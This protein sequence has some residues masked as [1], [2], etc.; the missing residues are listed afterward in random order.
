ME[1][2][3][4]FRK[5][6]VLFTLVQLGIPDLLSCRERATLQEIAGQLASG[7][8]QPSHD[9][10]ERLLGAGAALGLLE[11]QAGS[12][13]LSPVAREYLP[14]TA[15]LSLAG[16]VVHSDKVPRP[17]AAPAAAAAM[18]AAPRSDALPHGMWRAGGIPALRAAGALGAGRRQCLAARVRRRRQRH[19]RGHLPHDGG[20]AAVHGRHAQ[21]QPPQRAG[22]GVCL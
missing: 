21:L 7:Q 3:N 13:S 6:K 4:G 14:S 11:L 5:S 12:Y 16:Y 10:L 9:G 2:L 18:P 8:Q 20:R 19:L 17:P 1:L 22:R 15:E